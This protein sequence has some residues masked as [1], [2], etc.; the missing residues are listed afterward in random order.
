MGRAGLTVEY[1][2][3]YVSCNSGARI[4]LA[5]EVKSLFRVAWEDP[6]KPDMGF[7]YLYLTTEDYHKIAHLNSVIISE[8]FKDEGEER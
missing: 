7:K 2:Q 3:I 1:F 4:G 6:D 5:E 8:L